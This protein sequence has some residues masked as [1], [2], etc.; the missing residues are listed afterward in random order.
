MKKLLTVLLFPFFLTGSVSEQMP[1]IKSSSMNASV[2][3]EAE[4]TT[5]GGGCF[6]CLEPLF[7]S[8]RGVDEVISAYAGGKR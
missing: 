7:E 8:L 4:S 5:L 6:W 2:P 3:S 1:G